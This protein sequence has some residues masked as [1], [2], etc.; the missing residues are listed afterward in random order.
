MLNHVSIEAKAKAGHMA[1]N[2][3]RTT[4]LIRQVTAPTASELGPLI[5]DLWLAVLLS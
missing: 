5:R 2:E 4:D 3:H 1:N